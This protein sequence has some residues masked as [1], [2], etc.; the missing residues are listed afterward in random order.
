M[1]WVQCA[2]HP[3][4]FLGEKSHALL[5]LVASCPL[6]Q[7][8]LAPRGS[9]RRTL[10]CRLP[11]SFMERLALLSSTDPAVVLWPLGLVG[12]V[13]PWDECSL[14]H[15]GGL[16]SKQRGKEASNALQ[17]AQPRSAFPFHNE[18]AIMFSAFNNMTAEAAGSPSGRHPPSPRC[19]S[20]W[21]HKDN[22]DPKPLWLSPPQPRHLE[23]GA[24]LGLCADGAGLGRP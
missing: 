9:W 8:P 17:K 15:W 4:S 6:R 20:Q 24:A 2:Q 10:I 22:H 1:A 16:P 14:H 18:N 7:A 11:S 21:I 19:Q 13:Y 3:S 23:Q 12:H 5:V